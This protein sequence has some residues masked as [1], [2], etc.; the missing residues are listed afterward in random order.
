MSQKTTLDGFDQVNDMTYPLV[1][2]AVVAVLI[3]VAVI[4]LRKPKP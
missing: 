3:S 4:A 1:T 2:L